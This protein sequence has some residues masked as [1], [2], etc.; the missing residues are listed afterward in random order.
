MSVYVDPLMPRAPD[1]HWRWPSSCHLL[2]DTP[3]ELHN[4]AKD[5]RLRRSWFQGKANTPHYD[6]TANRR[7]T[8][9]VHGAIEVP[10]DRTFLELLKRI[11]ESWKKADAE[12][13]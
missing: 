9:V 5:I 10:H 4:F 12:R 1:R 6:L 13:H 3:E 8:A 11:R 7:A 2:A